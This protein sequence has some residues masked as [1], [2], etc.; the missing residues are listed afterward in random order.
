MGFAG[1]VRRKDEKKY[2]IK[3]VS[4]T[5][6]RSETRRLRKFLRS[7]TLID[8]RTD[9]NTELGQSEIYIMASG[10]SGRC[11]VSFSQHSG[12]LFLGWLFQVD[13][14]RL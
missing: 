1:G 13:L 3:Q 5:D 10:L 8:L 2:V 7:W 6:P 9:V 11:S 4:E 12:W 14:G